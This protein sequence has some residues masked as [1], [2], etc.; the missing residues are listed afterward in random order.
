MKR[1]E[2]TTFSVRIGAAPKALPR[3]SEHCSAS[4]TKGKLLACWYSDIGMLNQIMIIR[5][6]DDETEL[7][8]ERE[9]VLLGGNPFGIGEFIAA[10]SIDTYAPFPFLP[11]IEPGAQGPFYE[12]R[13]T[14]SPLT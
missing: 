13:A 7:A 6:F 8:S 12:V 14:F 1:Y 11:P 10:M 2:V 4:D 5:G 9:R 3:I